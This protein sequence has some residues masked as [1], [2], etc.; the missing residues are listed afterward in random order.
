MT[1]Q[2]S[3]KLIA[4][5]MGGAYEKNPATLKPYDDRIILDGS[6]V[7]VE[8]T[9]TGNYL[10]Y[11]ESWDWLMPVVEWIGVLD[12]DRYIRIGTTFVD[13]QGEYTGWIMTR[14]SLGNEHFNAPSLIEATYKAVV[15]YIE[16]YNKNKKD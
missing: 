3:N 1:T 11:H 6:I 9:G 5:F 7:Y 8:N 14:S 4:E 16:W 15:A 12:T 2:E 13:F 10:K